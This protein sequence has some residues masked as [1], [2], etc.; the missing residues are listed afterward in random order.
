[1]GIRGLG[2]STWSKFLYFF[3]VA[4]DLKRC[5]IYDLKIVDSLNKKQFSELD[6]HIW[7]QDVE[8][9]YQYIE[10]V[11]NL[12]KQMDVSPEQ[13]ELFL[14]YYNLSA[15][16]QSSKINRITQI[17]SSSILSYSL[18]AEYVPLATLQ[19][20]LATQLSLLPLEQLA[21]KE[22]RQKEQRNRS[23]KKP[24]NKNKNNNKNN[25]KSEKPKKESVSMEEA[26]R[27]LMERF[28]K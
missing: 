24:G 14:F 13:V 3:N 27:R 6:T 2:I 26:T 25:V 16:I 11:D 7:K 21:Q 10:L 5:K 12:A 4:I 8:H 28:G 23:F 22:A 1:M 19:T 17:L 18:P 9:Y 15:I 20:E